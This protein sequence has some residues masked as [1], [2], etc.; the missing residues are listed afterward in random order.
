MILLLLC[1][2]SGLSLAC[3]SQSINL[4]TNDLR[5]YTFLEKGKL[6][7][8]NDY[9]HFAYSV[10]FTKVEPLLIQLHQLTLIARNLTS[11]NYPHADV[12]SALIDE[13]Y[14]LLN[15]FY[16][17]ICHFFQPTRPRSSR[18]P[19]LIPSSVVE[20]SSGSREG[21][22]PETSTEPTSRN[23]IDAILKDDQQNL[24]SLNPGHQGK[25]RRKR[26]SDTPSGA[27]LFRV[28][29]F[30]G[31]VATLITGLIAGGTIFGLFDHS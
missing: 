22:S 5:H 24:S 18:N 15:N 20:E 28:K 11:S 12:F 10:N 3:S 1:L 25:K 27:P 9:G 30:F 8:A 2:L 19:N 21:L 14:R 13:E 31:Y 17:N 4:S 7:T 23:H 26:V 29:R 16:K 6:I